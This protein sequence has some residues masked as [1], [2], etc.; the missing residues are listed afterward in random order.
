M[1]GVARTLLRIAV[2]T[3]HRTGSSRLGR[4]IPSHRRPDAVICR[5]SQI[6]IGELFHTMVGEIGTYSL[7]VSIL[8]VD[9][10]APAS[11]TSLS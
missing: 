3:L 11:D 5:R 7:L 6:V 2:D 8:A 10:N 4:V 1:E 9:T